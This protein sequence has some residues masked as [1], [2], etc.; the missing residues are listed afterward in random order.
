MLSRYRGGTPGSLGTYIHTKCTLWM[1]DKLALSAKQKTRVWREE[2]C[3]A[4]LD[5]FG[6]GRHG[7]CL[8]WTHSPGALSSD[9]SHF[10]GLSPYENY[11]NNWWCIEMNTYDQTRDVILTIHFYLLRKLVYN[12]QNAPD[13]TAESL[14]SAQLCACSRGRRANN[15]MVFLAGPG[16]FQKLSGRPIRHAF[17]LFR[18]YASLVMA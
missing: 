8:T 17:L 18:W 14:H 16:S 6:L 4:W 5:P 3:D 11:M 1:R 9:E 13:W 10:I 12:I 7:S 15:S 2:L